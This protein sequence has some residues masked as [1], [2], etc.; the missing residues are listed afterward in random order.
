MKNLRRLTCLCSSI[1]IVATGLAMVSGTAAANFWKK[2]P[3]LPVPSCTSLASDSAYGLKDHPLI[4]SVSAEITTTGGTAGVPY[5]RVT[6]V[7]GENPEQNIIIYIG[8]PLSP[9]D[10]GSGRVVGAWNGRT[11]GLGGG[12]CTGTLNVDPAVNAGYVG[13]GTDGGHPIGPSAAIGDC[14][15]WVLEDGTYSHHIQDFFRHGIKQQ[16]LWSK[17]VARTYYSVHP[18]Y[19]YWNGCSTGGRQGYLLA[20][21]LG[22][23]LDGILANAPAMYWTRFATAQAWGQIAMFELAEQSP[24][25]AIAPAK[26]AAVRQAAVAA[27]DAND[28]VVDG[29]ID[30]PRTCD[31]DANNAV[32]GQPGAPAAPNCLTTA[33]ATAVN[34]I[35]DGPR[36]NDGNRIW[37]PIERGTDFGGLN[38]PGVFPFVQ[39]QFEWN[40]KDRSYAYP[41]VGAGLFPTSQKWNTVTLT[42][43]NNTLSYA[44]VAQDGSR[45]IADVTDTFGDLDKFRRSGG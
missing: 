35:W 23:E 13:S 36:N 7:Y 41:L 6:L 4:K 34:K 25:G 22:D 16:I 44:Q 28:G 17:Q 10:G 11:Q 30:D 19:N 14:A 29:V 2:K 21:E 38:G 39:I 9:V 5:C 18:S 37:F 32:C 12:V 24:P 45:N 42:G 1:V 40:E 33:E 31:Y 20:Q 27:C 15:T 3:H 8:L 43:A 26:L